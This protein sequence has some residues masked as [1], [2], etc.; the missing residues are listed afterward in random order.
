MER[1]YY[2]DVPTGPVAIR[3]VADLYLYP[4]TVTLVAVSGATVREWLE[5]SAGIFRQVRPGV[6]DQPLHRC[7]LPEL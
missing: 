3:N 2:T 5:R 6:A 7:H 1:Y 4:N